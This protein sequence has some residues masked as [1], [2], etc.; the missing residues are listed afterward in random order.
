MKKSLVQQKL[1][2]NHIY[3][4]LTLNFPIYVLYFLCVST[5]LMLAVWTTKK[6]QQICIFKSIIIFSGEAVHGS[7]ETSE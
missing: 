7:A 5:A 4:P 6:K 3:H 2:K 1:C